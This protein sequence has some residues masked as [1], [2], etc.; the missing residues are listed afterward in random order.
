MRET[1]DVVLFSQRM[2]PAKLFKNNFQFS[3]PNLQDAL[4]EIFS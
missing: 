4:K 2:I 3:Y 1:A